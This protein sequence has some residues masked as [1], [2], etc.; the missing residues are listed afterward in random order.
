MPLEHDSKKA[1]EQPDLSVSAL[2]TLP[3]ALIDSSP[4]TPSSFH[5]F[6]HVYYAFTVCAVWCWSR[7]GF[8]LGP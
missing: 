7:A 1:S 5:S 4:L 2:V 3:R 8:E 6:Y